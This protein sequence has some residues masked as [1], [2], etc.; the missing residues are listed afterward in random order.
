MPAPTAETTT[1][2]AFLGVARSETGRRWVGPAPEH[3][4]QAQRL[5]RIAPAQR[6]KQRLH[7]IEGDKRHEQAVRGRAQVPL[8]QQAEQDDAKS[9]RG[10]EGDG[11]KQ[12][13]GI[14][15]GFDMGRYNLERDPGRP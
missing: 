7:K 15:Q 6:H 1:Q 3:D 11:D 2:G 4:R 10:E 5:D 13:R 12:H 9:G 8:R 14:R